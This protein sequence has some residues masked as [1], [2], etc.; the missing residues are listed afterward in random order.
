MRFWTLAIHNLRRRP[1]RSVLT[2]LGI[3]MAVACLVVLLGL[4]RG[5]EQA[6]LTNLH[7]RGTH[8]LAIQKGTVDLMAASLDAGLGEQLGRVEGVQTVA[9]SLAE[10]L[11]F[12]EDFNAIAEGWPEGCYL[13]KS[14]Q[15]VQGRLPGAGET[16]AVLLGQSAAE[17]LRK[18]PGDSLKLWGG[19]PVVVGVFRTSGVL[20]NNSL[21]LPLAELQRLQ[22]RPGKVT[23]FHV[24]VNRP[25]ETAAVQARLQTAFPSLSVMPTESVAE[26]NQMLRLIRAIAWSFSVVAGVIALVVV[27]NTLLMSVIEQTREIGILS[28][29]GWQTGRI[30]ALIL[31]EG[32]LLGFL[33]ALIGLGIG[34][35][36][37]E[38]LTSLPRMQGL[39]EAEMSVQLLGEVLLT[40]TLL[41][42]LGSLYP[43]WRAARLD[44]VE[45][46]Q[47]E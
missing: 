13:W 28:A 23:A 21:I 40:A 36:G 6:W 24:R 22:Q 35:G 3:A 11:S 14:V 12:E 26:N 1:L 10:L 45:A 15:L 20:G 8:L 46:L 43:A 16:N 32:L 4:S 19:T 27:L 44:P 18:R 31:W 39:I 25:E 34:V 37:L 38:G 17:T 41:G 47:Y 9:G 33:G 5:L 7:A 42:V 29:V 2:V 30:M